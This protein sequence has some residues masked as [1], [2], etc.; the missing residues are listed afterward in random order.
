MV[1][2]GLLRSAFVLCLTGPGISPAELRE[3]YITTVGCEDGFGPQGLQW[4]Q[5]ACSRRGRL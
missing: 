5:A 4:G 2:R 3:F 1:P